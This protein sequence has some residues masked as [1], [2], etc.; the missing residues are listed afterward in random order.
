VEFVHDRGD[1]E[2]C[3]VHGNIELAGDE[4]VGGAVD[5]ERR[6]LAFALAEVGNRQ[7]GAAVVFGLQQFFLLGANEFGWFADAEFGGLNAVVLSAFVYGA[8]VVL[9]VLFE[10]GGAAAVGRR[11]VARLSPSDIP[12]APRGGRST[13]GSEPERNDDDPTA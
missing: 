13:P 12:S 5:Q 9:V 6:H 11:L 10:P 4:L 3:R 1:V 8:A 7:V 2:F